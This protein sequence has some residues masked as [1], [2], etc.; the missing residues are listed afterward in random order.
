MDDN[1]TKLAIVAANGTKIDAM[2][3]KVTDLVSAVADM[4]ADHVANTIKLDLINRIM[5]GKAVTDKNTG[6]Y[7]I[8]DADDT[9]ILLQTNLYEDAA[10]TIAYRGKGI[11]RRN[12]MITPP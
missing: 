8:Y 12:R 7:T 4:E 1:S 9:T 2:D 5:T 10:G 6:T 11:A 3:A